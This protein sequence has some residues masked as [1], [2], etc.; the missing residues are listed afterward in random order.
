MAL[1]LLRNHR[2]VINITGETVS[3]RETAPTLSNQPDGDGMAQAGTTIRK[4]ETRGRKL[5]MAVIP[6]VREINYGGHL[7]IYTSSANGAP[8]RTCWTRIVDDL[9]RGWRQLV[10]IVT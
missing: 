10:G 4:R 7:R 3:I 6:F 2:S 1:R 5:D 9:L 8:A